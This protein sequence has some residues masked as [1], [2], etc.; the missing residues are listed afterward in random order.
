[1]PVFDDILMKGVRSGH[2]PA[3]TEEARSWYRR[4][5][6]NA[7]VQEN[8]LLQDKS[9]TQRK[10]QPGSMYMFQYDPKTKDKLPYYDRFPM[11]FPVDLAKGGFYGIN[12]HYLPHRLRARLMDELYK[13]ATND[14]FDEKTKLAITYKVLKGASKLRLYKPCF[15]RYLYQHLQSNFVYIYPSEWDMALFLPLER[16]EKASLKTVHDASTRMVYG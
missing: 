3:R 6:A 15:K 16:F 9:R 12:L 2:V 1:M 8:Q 13:Y 4:V 10:V 14:K 7:N 5:A 11:I